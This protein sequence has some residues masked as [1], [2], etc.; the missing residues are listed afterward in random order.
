LSDGEQRFYIVFDKNVRAVTNGKGEWQEVP[1]RVPANAPTN[2]QVAHDWPT[3]SWF[4]G[5]AKL[6]LVGGTRIWGQW[7]TLKDNYQVWQL[8][9]PPHQTREVAASVG[10]ATPQER[11]SVAAVTAPPPSP[12]GVTITAEKDGR[13]VR[14]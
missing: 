7:P 14:A 4:A 10:E 3:T 12:Q 5:S 2:Y 1:A 13:R 8:T 6:T 9:L 11:E